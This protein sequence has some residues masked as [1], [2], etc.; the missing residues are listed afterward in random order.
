MTGQTSKISPHELWE[1]IETRQKTHQPHDTNLKKIVSSTVIYPNTVTQ[2]EPPVPPIKG[3]SKTDQ[4][5]KELITKNFQAMLEET[6]IENVNLLTGNL[7]DIFQ[8]LQEGTLGLPNQNSNNQQEVEKL[9]TEKCATEQEIFQLRTA[10]KTEIK[11]LNKNF[12][13][14]LKDCQGKLGTANRQNQIL[15]DQVKQLQT[16]QNTFIDLTG[17]THRQKIDKLQTQH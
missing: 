13:I 3:S 16:E 2:P 11:N 8:N 7:A 17:K 10:L 5:E 14:K 1:L 4:N 15:N 9:K 6:S 12:D